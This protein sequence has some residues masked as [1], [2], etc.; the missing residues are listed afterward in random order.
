M[1]PTPYLFF[2]GDCF[3]AMSLYAETLGGRVVHVMRNSDAAG[4]EDRMP[5]GDDAV[6]N[7][8]IEVEGRAMFG[9][10]NSSEMY[11]TPQGFRLQLE[12]PS[13]EAFERVHAALSKDA[14]ATDMEAGETFWAERFTMFTDRFGTPWMLN[15]TGSKG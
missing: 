13:L 6:M 5:G 11:R 14:R 10:D 15:F 4:P 1:H 12:L 8:V 9:S 3:A 7:M 2:R